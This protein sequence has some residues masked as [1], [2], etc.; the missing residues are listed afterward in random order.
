MCRLS[1]ARVD[2]NHPPSILLLGSWNL[3]FPDSR[4]GATCTPPAPVVPH[5]HVTVGISRIANPTYKRSLS[6]RAPILRTPI[7][8]DPLT[9]IPTI[10]GFDAIGISRI[11]ISLLLLHQ[12]G[13]PTRDMPICDVAYA[14]MVPVTL[15][16]WLHFLLGFKPLDV[17]ALNSLQ[18]SQDL[19]VLDPS[20]N[21]SR[22]FQPS[23]T[24][25]IFL[26]K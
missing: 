2:L 10:N 14:M 18:L 20:W 8:R 25:W 24:L 1:D 15:D 6:S 12:L 4:Y 5:S 7:L 11:A 22:R 23:I 19:T 16:R 26:A 9:C 17:H 13:A 21:L 3:P